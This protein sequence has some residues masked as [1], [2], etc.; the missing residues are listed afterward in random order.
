MFP[1][2]FT[3]NSLQVASKAGISRG[4]FELS[5]VGNKWCSKCLPNDTEDKTKLSSIVFFEPTAHIYR[6]YNYTAEISGA[7]FYDMMHLET[8]KTAQSTESLGCASPSCH[9]FG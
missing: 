1:T 5:T 2:Y 6:K 8:C 9:I 3:S 4:S 7:Y